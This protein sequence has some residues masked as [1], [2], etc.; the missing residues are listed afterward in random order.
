MITEPENKKNK[1]LKFFWIA[2]FASSL[3]FVAINSFGK[4]M[5][6]YFFFNEIAK[7]PNL[8][9]AQVSFEIPKKEEI[10][11]EV[12]AEP[13]ENSLEISAKSAIS[14]LF[15]PDTKEE[16]TVFEKESN[17]VLPIA[18]LTKLMVADIVLEN[19]DLNRI[20]K[21]SE[22]AVSQAGNIGNLKAGEELSVENLLY[23]T[24]IESSNDAAYALSETIGV[25]SFVNLMNIYAEY[26]G[27]KDT[28]FI[29]PSGLDYLQS[30]N[31]ST[32]NDL[33]KLARYILGNY[34]QIFA[35]TTLQSYEV[36]SPDGS[37]HHKIIQNTNE[38]L[39]EFP[40]IIGGKTGLS[41]KANGCLLLIL[42]DSKSSNY[43]INVILGS[44]DR[45]GEMK[46]IIQTI[47]FEN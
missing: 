16:K 44:D 11:K 18:S 22:D 38:L 32:A 43:Y 29:N 34:P 47:D 15:S 30:S 6:D 36:L 40:E 14:V 42:T 25:N 41:P 45:F 10:K 3:F 28:N 24:L 35:I 23:M 46:K 20:I 27:L 4:N 37:V 2:F 39:G 33:A 19:Y 7:N 26:I 5:E 13:E 17:M 12:K 8:F 9:R 31:S 21:I 1:G